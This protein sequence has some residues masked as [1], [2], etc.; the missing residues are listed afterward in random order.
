MRV[1]VRTAALVLSLGLVAVLGAGS[2][3]AA[4][5][6]VTI[7]GLAFSPPSVTVNE[8]DTVTWTNEDGM[9]HTATGSGGSFDTGTLADGASAAV[10]FDTAGTFAYICSIHPTMTGTVIV[11]AA[12]T[13]APSTEAPAT[14]AP[15][16]DGP[17]TDA[18]AVT[19][20]AT[21]TAPAEP[22]D[23]ASSLIA[24]LLAL[25][26]DRDARPDRGLEPATFH[27]LTLRLR[28]AP[29]GGAC[30]RPPAG[31]V[32]S[33]MSWPTSSRS[34]SM[35][36]R[37]GF[38]TC[39]TCGRCCR[40]RCPR[41]STRPS[42]CSSRGGAG[43]VPSCSS[44]P[45]TSRARATCGSWTRPVSTGPRHSPSSPARPCGSPRARP[46]SMASSSSSM[47]MD[48]A[49]A[50]ALAERLDGKPGRPAAFLAFDLLHLD[51]RSLLGQP[52]I[53]RRDALRRVLRPGDEVVA[54]PAIATEGL[55]L[56]DAIVGQG[57]AGMMARQRGGPYLPGQRSRLWRYVP[58]RAGTIPDAELAA[59]PAE[60]AATTSG[61]APVLALLSRLPL[62]EA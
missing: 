50:A 43:C 59:A 22:T 16:S 20:A 7:S 3:A 34:P 17:A 56:F 32:P 36:P 48:G 46:S 37:T 27:R 45:P 30:G 53:K 61:T 44:V 41:P 13:A 25:L 8:G 29:A 47:P 10:T 4:D 14:D 60:P 49:D 15:A 1:F 38:R 51:G 18:P 62:D 26:G 55:A 54:V 40:G 31:G 12:A 23:D 58:A 57:L 6:T 39:R 5:Q 9:P 21:D 19:P 42:T 35:R 52:L 24:P 28:A 33:A 2:V 11:E